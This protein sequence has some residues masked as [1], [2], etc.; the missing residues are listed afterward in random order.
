MHFCAFLVKSGGLFSFFLSSLAF[1]GFF[2]LFI[3]AT[4]FLVFQL[5]FLYIFVIS[6]LFLSLEDLLQGLK[7]FVIWCKHW[8]NP[9]SNAHC[10][11]VIC[12]PMH[13]QVFLFTQVYWVAL[14]WLLIDI[15]PWFFVP[16]PVFVLS[17]NYSML[18]IIFTCLFL[19]LIMNVF[20]F[21]KKIILLWSSH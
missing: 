21:W 17:S 15:Y 5:I 12:S 10:P 7:S 1:G 19:L 13:V 4:N 9:W 8:V 3:V 14:F 6:P 16:F 20:K 2:F 18:H 11:L